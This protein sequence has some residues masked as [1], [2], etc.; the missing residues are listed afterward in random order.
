MTRQSAARWTLSAVAFAVLLLPAAPAQTVFSA[1]QAGDWYDSGPAYVWYVSGPGTNTYPQ[2]GDI[3]N[4]GLGPITLSADAWCDSLNLTATSTVGTVSLNGHNLI[5]YGDTYDSGWL[6]GVVQGAGCVSNF[7]TVALASGDMVVPAQFNNNPGGSVLFATDARMYDGGT[8]YNSGT[9][10]KSG[11]T[12][13]SKLEKT[14]CN[15]GGAVAVQSGTL[16]L[17]NGSGTSEGGTFSVSDGA[18]LNLT[19]VTGTSDHYLTGVYSGTGAGRI[20]F[21]AGGDDLHTA[22][23]GAVFNFEGDLFQWNGGTIYSD[24]VLS[25]IG[26]IN[27]AGADAKTL[28]RL[29]N[30][31]TINHGGSADLGVWAGCCITNAAGALYDIRGDLGLNHGGGGG[32]HPEFCNEAGATL[33]KSAGTGTSTVDLVWHNLGG[34]IEVQSGTLHFPRTSGS[35]SGASFEVAAGAVLDVS[36]ASGGHNWQGPYAGT[37]DGEVHLS[38]VGLITILSNAATFNFPTNMFQWSGGTINA[39]NAPVTNS[40]ALHLVGAGGRTFQ[41]RLENEG[42]VRHTGTGP[43]TLSGG[44]CFLNNRSGALYDLQDDGD[45][46]GGLGRHVNNW[47]TLRKSGGTGTSTVGVLWCNYDGVVEV[48]SG[49]LRFSWGY[50]TNFGATFNVAAGAVVDLST[51]DGGHR[52]C[53]T[54]SGTGEGEVRLDTSAAALAIVS[55]GAT[56]NFPT[57]MFRWYG[58]RIDATGGPFTNSGVINLAGSGAPELYGG[59]LEN[60]GSIQHTGT[61]TFTLWAGGTYVNNRAGALYD[62]RDDGDIG[63][64][65]GQYFNNWGTLRKSG[66][67]DTSAVHI[68]WNNYDGVVDVQSG[69]L[70]F[71]QG[72]GVSSGGTFSVASGAILDLSP[73]TEKHHFGGTFAGTGDGEIHL[74]SDGDRI[75]ILDG[76]AVFDFPS[77]M[78]QWYLGNIDARS[79]PLTNAGTVNLAGTGWRRLYG[80][81]CNAGRVNHAGACEL[82]LWNGGA[83]WNNLNGAVYELQDDGGLTGSKAFTNWGTVV[84]SGGTGTSTL[85]VSLLNGGT[86]EVQSGTLA[87]SASCIQT[88]G[89]IR[90]NGGNLTVG[91]GGYLTLADGVLTGTGTV[92]AVKVESSGSVAPGLSVGQLIL[93]AAY[94]QNAAGSLDIELGGTTAGSGYDQLYV[95]GSVS[96]GGTLNV[97][98]TN[99]FNPAAGDRFEIIKS[100]TVCSANFSTTNLPALDPGLS[101]ILTNATGTIQDLRVASAADTDGDGLDDEWENTYFLDLITSDGGTNDNDGDGFTD[102]GEQ[103]ASTD[104]TNDASRLEVDFAAMIAGTNV[105]LA[106]ETRTGVVYRAEWSDLLVTS[107][108][109]WTEFTNFTGD[110]ASVVLTN[111][112]PTDT[113]LRYYRLRIERP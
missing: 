41:G 80:D 77:D 28:L 23:D 97:S 9:I 45:F 72:T 42:L 70:R 82:D 18:V 21:D 74:A 66:G 32:S 43:L 46:D 54:S 15:L 106:F 50:G 40:G 47:G 58:G 94:Q 55:D 67:T 110:G 30:A 71:S 113:T 91:G 38:G 62:L 4:I 59:T 49:T 14:W 12:A 53:G 52:W 57:N 109:T 17:C 10:V 98:L 95:N 75:V 24:V 6:G 48:E 87:L 103:M 60:E 68:V 8:F 93:S 33:R 11:G 5:I 35:S 85:N 112:V 65:T 2:V 25:N 78:F 20:H 51:T 22:G 100:T 36:T 31:G 76:G 26:T 79:G 83:S 107:P 81:F 96:A 13:T 69:V 56:F 99:G 7:G 102:F 73:S 64:G 27:L 44:A 90:L 84:K 1:F 34:A 37:G 19:P 86:V 88:N 92:S 3:V 105:P 89:V 29:I 108:V 101:W 111:A 63:N 16:W 39:L 61:C 104:P